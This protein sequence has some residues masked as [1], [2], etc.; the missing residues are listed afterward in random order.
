MPLW[1]AERERRRK[2]REE[3]KEGREEGEFWRL[4]LLSNVNHY[5]FG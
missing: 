1:G 3:G 4:F 2:G 5:Y